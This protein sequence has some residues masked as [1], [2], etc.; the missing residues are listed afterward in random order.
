M[1]KVVF[2]SFLC[3]SLTV[4]GYVY[5]FYYHSF[6]DGYREGYFQK[7]SRR[8]DVFKTYEAELVVQGFGARVATQ[9]NSSANYF[10]FSVLDEALADSLEHC[11]GKMLKVHYV[12][13]KRSL[14]WRG[15]DYNTR[16]Q[17]KGQFIVDRIE[18]VNN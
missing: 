5:W 2:L 13:Y 10:Y 4:T 16:N 6:G 14:P 1:K 18:Q 7:F 11:L 8:G 17:D 9:S 3:I 12:Q 15:E